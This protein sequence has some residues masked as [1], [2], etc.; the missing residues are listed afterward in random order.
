MGLITLKLERY[1]FKNEY[2]INDKNDNFSKEFVVLTLFYVFY[3]LKGIYL[4]IKN[5]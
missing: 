3:I 4:L 5:I 2:K 1:K